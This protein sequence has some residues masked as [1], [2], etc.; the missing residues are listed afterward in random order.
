MRVF[1]DGGGAMLARLTSALVRGCLVAVMILVPS[2]LV[3]SVARDTSEIVILVAFFAAVLTTIEYASSYPSIVEF[4]DAPPFNRIRYISLLISLLLISVVCRG[5]MQPSAFTNF[6]QA[7]GA[8]IG[9]VIDF[10]MSP[11]RLMLLMLPEDTGPQDVAL[12]RM[13]AGL[14]YLISL[15]SLAVFVIVLRFAGWP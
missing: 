4:R 5:E 14:A 9:Q 6:V 3:P 10:P 8:L 11:V 7:V 12:M 1:G 15:V 13:A 2:L